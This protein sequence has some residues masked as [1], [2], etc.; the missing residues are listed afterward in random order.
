[1][2][3]SRAVTEKRSKRRHQKRLSKATWPCQEYLSGHITNL[4]DQLRLVDIDA[5]VGAYCLKLGVTKR[6]ILNFETIYH[7]ITLPVSFFQ[8]HPTMSSCLTQGQD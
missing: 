2:K 3:I 8:A 6:K 5:V 1:M 7:L 4:E